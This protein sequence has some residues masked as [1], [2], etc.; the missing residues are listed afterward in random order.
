MKTFWF[1]VA[2]AVVLTCICIQ[3][4]SA[5]PGT[6]V[7]EPEEPEEPVSI[8]SLVSDQEEP[9]EDSWKMPSSI[10]EKRGVKCSFRCR[11]G[12]CRLSCKKRRG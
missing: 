9:S 3:E 5:V 8:E 4:S 11:R 12:V 1:A 6:E 2:V 10:R 7:Q